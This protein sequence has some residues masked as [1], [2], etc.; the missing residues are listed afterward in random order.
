[1]SDI[2]TAISTMNAHGQQ[3]I[4]I[5]AIKQ[6][7]EAE[8]QIIAMIDQLVDSSQALSSSGRGQLVNTYA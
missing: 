8:K 4:S 1:M 3:S 7:V 6:T 5:A 2:V